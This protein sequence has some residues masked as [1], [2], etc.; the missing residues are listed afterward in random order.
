MEELIKVVQ[1]ILWLGGGGIIGALLTMYK[2]KAEMVSKSECS[3]S[4]E[5]CNKFIHAILNDLKSSIEAIRSD[6][7]VLRNGNNG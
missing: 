3:N 2:V 5:G 6:I 7:Y 4:R 1:V